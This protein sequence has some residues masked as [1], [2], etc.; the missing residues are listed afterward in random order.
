MKSVQMLMIFLIANNSLAVENIAP[1]VQVLDSSLKIELPLPKNNERQKYEIMLSPDSGYICH[2]RFREQ[3]IKDKL[4]SLQTKVDTI[5][6]LQNKLLEKEK[7]TSFIGSD[8]WRDILIG[9][10]I[11]SVSGFVISQ[12]LK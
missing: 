12:K 2:N 3:E 7:P 10:A 9:F 5:P 11:G 4:F 1:Q 8:T 6:E